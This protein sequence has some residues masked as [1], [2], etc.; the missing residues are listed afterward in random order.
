MISDYEN[1]P[2]LPHGFDV[3]LL[4]PMFQSHLRSRGYWGQIS[5]EFVVSDGE[6]RVKINP[7]TYSNLEAEQYRDGRLFLTDLKKREFIN[8]LFDNDLVC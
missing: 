5:V 1:A 8:S 6:D 7:N 3:T 2:I 4:I